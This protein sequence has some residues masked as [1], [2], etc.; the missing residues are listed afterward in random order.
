MNV[1]ELQGKASVEQKPPVDKKNIPCKLN[2]LSKMQGISKT[3]IKLL[4]QN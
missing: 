2:K 4:I 1:R 3:L